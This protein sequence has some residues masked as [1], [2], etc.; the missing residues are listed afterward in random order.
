MRRRL[1]GQRHRARSASSDTSQETQDDADFVPSVSVDSPNLTHLV[2]QQPQLQATQNRQHMPL[3]LLRRDVSDNNNNPQ[4]Q[5]SDNTDAYDSDSDDETDPYFGTQNAR[6]D[7]LQMRRQ[8]AIQA[9]APTFRC[10]SLECMPDPD[11]MGAPP[12]VR[13]SAF[14]TIETIQLRCVCCGRLDE[15]EIFY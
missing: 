4:Q 14:S 13:Q 6:E 2:Q 8:A 3:T 12:L 10:M 9:M 1:F 15:V 5:I 11:E 7:A